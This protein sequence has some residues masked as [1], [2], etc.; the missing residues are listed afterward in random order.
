MTMFM[1]QISV[2]DD[3]FVIKAIAPGDDAGTLDAVFE[4]YRSA[5]FGINQSFFR[6]PFTTFNR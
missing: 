3:S 2:V 1:P 6:I 5:K 4:L